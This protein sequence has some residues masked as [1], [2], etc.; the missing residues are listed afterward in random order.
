MAAIK[1]LFFAGI[2]TVSQLV[3]GFVLAKVFAIYLGPVGLALFSQLQNFIQ[4][5]Q[6]FSG[7]VIQNGTIKYVA[8]YHNNADNKQRI[9][10]TSL[11]LAAICSLIISILLIIFSKQITVHLFKNV[12]YQAILII[13][14]LTIIF[15]VYNTLIQSVLNGEGDNKTYTMSICVGMLLT[16]S[17]NCLLAYCFQLQGAMYAFVLNPILLFC[18]TLAFVWKKTWI[19]TLSLF[20]QFDYSLLKKLAIIALPSLAT[21]MSVPITQLLLR[22]Y[23]AIHFSWEAAGWWQSISRISDMYLLLI[24]NALMLYYLPKLSALTTNKQVKQAIKHGFQF[25]L[26]LAAILAVGIFIFKHEIIFI[27]FTPSFFSALPLFKYQLLG[28]LF[29]VCSW[30]ISYALFGR[31]MTNILLFTEILFAIIYYALAVTL[32]N[33]YGLSGVPMAFMVSYAVYFLTLGSYCYYRLNR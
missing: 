31:A 10:A 5:L 19:R 22:N 17:I 4:I 26:P 7:I 6:N 12:H 11:T 1:S 20:R 3:N 2:K 14:A 18:I 33:R 25:F 21:T 16:L 32:S 27:L 30:L 9:I 13:S 29:K 23:I 28:D 8:E 15:S 24:S